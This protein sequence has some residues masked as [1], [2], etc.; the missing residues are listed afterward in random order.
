MVGALTLY[1]ESVWIPFLIVGYGFGASFV[2][3]R[4][5]EWSSPDEMIARL[6]LKQQVVLTEL[7]QSDSGGIEQLFFSLTATSADHPQEA[8]A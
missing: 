7:R 3:R 4:R 2:A 8:A 6:A 5:N 1:Q